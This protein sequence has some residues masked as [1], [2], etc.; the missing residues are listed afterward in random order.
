MMK[1]TRPDIL[2]VVR[3]LSRFMTGASQ[4]HMKE[5]YRA[6]KYCVGNLNVAYC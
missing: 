6:M 5:M 4:A 3:D 1:W 2:N